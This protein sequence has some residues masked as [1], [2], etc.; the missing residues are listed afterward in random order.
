MKAARNEILVLV[1]QGSCTA[2]VIL[3]IA[4]TC[5]LSDSSV[6][7]DERSEAVRIDHG[8]PAVLFRDNSRSPQ[9]LSGID[10]LINAA[11][12]TEV[13]AWDPNSRG[14]SAG[15]NFEHI[16][17]G[18]QNPN[19]KLMPRIGRYTFQKVPRKN[20]VV[21]TRCAEDSPWEIASTLK[22][23]VRAPHYVD[24]DFLCTPQDVSLF[25]LR[26]YAIFFFA[27]YMNDVENVLLNVRGHMS[28]NTP[29][30]WIAADAPPGHPDWRSG[31]NYRALQADDLQYDEDVQFRLNTWSYD[32]PRI[33]RPFY[34]GRAGCAMTLILMFDRDRS[35]RDQMRFSL[36]KFKLK[37][38]P[39]PAWEFQ[40]VINRVEAGSRYGF[41]GRLVWKKCVSAD[42]CRDEYESWAV[43]V[44]AQQAQLRQ[45]RI[46]QLR[47]LGAVVFTQ[48]DDVVEVSANRTKIS[49][50]DLQL[51]SDFTQLTDLSLEETSVSDNGL[52]HVRDLHKIEWLNLYRTEIGDAG[53]QTLSQL[54]SLQHLPVGETNVTDDGLA[55]LKDMRQLLYLGVRANHVTDDGVKHLSELVNLTGLHL[56]ETLVTSAGLKHLTSMARLRTLWLDG[57]QVSDNAIATLVRLTSL[58]ELHIIGTKITAKGL[59]RLQARLPRCRIIGPEP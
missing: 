38:V 6:R 2:L 28:R 37:N 12:T 3:W 17:S 41:R 30:T 47:E 39:R 27:S 10:S 33:V 44:R 1:N 4:F 14:A 45:D 20:S 13:D 52:V 21:L 11:Q 36:C 15:L 35:E 50:T 8:D 42:G 29:E 16:I 24:F 19:N 49:D 56:G 54:R 40:Y 51:I 31:G 32:W 58:R 53:L 34:F 57:T 55:H 5:A 18:H 22:Y 25:D 46:R 43:G 7:A 23:T 59:K 9:L 26:G 48:G